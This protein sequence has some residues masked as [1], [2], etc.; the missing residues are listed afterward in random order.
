MNKL[1]EN[2]T[3]SESTL[4]EEVMKEINFFKKA[5]EILSQE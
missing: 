3:T 5:E 1:K 4:F 2:L